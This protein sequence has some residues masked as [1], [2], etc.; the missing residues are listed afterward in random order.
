MKAVLPTKAP[1]GYQDAPQSC[2][3]ACPSTTTLTRSP[4][5]L[6]HRFLD[7]TCPSSLQD[8][9][10]HTKVSAS[11]GFECEVWLW[12]SSHCFASGYLSSSKITVGISGT[13]GSALKL[14]ITKL[15]SQWS[16]FSSHKSLMCLQQ[17]MARLPASHLLQKTVRKV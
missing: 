1:S 17:C 15:F 9:I 14:K 13:I 7:H 10:R 8:I 12:P 16:I 2:H 3:G 6:P 5:S 4:T 11:S